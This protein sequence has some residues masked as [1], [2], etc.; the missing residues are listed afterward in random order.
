MLSCF[1]LQLKWQE[2]DIEEAVEDTEQ[3]EFADIENKRAAAVEKDAAA[4]K[5]SQKALQQPE[6]LLACI[7]MAL[8]VV[9]CE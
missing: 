3:K 9:Q 4:A 7:H 6:Y 1:I 5:Q 2:I 8:V